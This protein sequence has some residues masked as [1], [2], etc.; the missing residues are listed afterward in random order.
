MTPEQINLAIAEWRGWTEVMERNHPLDCS[1]PVLSGYPPSHK[2]IKSIPDYYN[3]LNACR[4]ALCNLPEDKRRNFIRTLWGIIPKQPQ[5]V[6]DI[7]MSYWPMITAS[8]D[9]IC[10]SLLRTLGLWKE[11]TK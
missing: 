11:E 2:Y 8:P 7:Q 3:D 4:E 10:E 5:D 9:K 1:I 6:Y